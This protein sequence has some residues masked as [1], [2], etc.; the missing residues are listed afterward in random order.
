MIEESR[1]NRAILMWVMAVVMG[2]RMGTGSRVGM[3]GT[4]VGG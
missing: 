3:V 4:G 1:M 2:L